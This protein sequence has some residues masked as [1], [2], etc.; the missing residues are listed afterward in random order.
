MKATFAPIFRS[1]VDETLRAVLSEAQRTSFELLRERRGMCLD[2]YHN[3]IQVRDGGKDEYLKHYSGYRDEA[4]VWTFKNVQ[5]LEHLNLTER[6]ID[7]KSRTYREQPTRLVEGEEAV[8]YAA[9]LEKSR[10][11]A[12]SKRVEAYT[13]LLHDVAVGVFYNPNKEKWTYAV[14][15]DYYPVFDEEDPLQID[16]VAI[17]YPTAKRSDDGSVIYAYYDATTHVEMTSDYAIV[18]EEPNSFGVFNFFFPHKKVPVINHFSTPAV[19]LVDANQAID[20]AL[21]GLNQG[22]HYNSHK[23]LVIKGTIAKKNE[24]DQSVSFALGNAQVITIDVPMDSNANSLGVD[25]LD[26]SVDFTSHIAAI[27]AKMRF[28]FDSYNLSGQYKIEGDAAS[29]YSLDLQ[30]AKDYEDRRDR[31]DIISD[32][33]EKPLH[34]IVA[35]IA[36]KY[37]IT[38]EEGELTLDYAEPKT[39]QSITDRIAWQKWLIES[40]QKTVPEIMVENNPEMSLEDAEKQYQENLQK[41]QERQKDVIDQPGVQDPNRGQAGDSSDDPSGRAVGDGPGSE[42][43]V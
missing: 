36:G 4:N 18:S 42:D 6:V 22:L 8:E 31:Y 26:M 16:P 33:I 17:V 9:L 14:I 25:V 38:V 39:E 10:W 29:G 41:A 3:E 30:N 37:G 13:N 32:Y 27:Q 7:L 34:E 24:R 28:V 19:D 43:S 11:F 35:A 23:Q 12:I 40:H 15:T 20:A 5:L 21:T 1:T 2:Y